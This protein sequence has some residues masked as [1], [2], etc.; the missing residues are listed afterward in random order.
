MKRLFLFGAIVLAALIAISFISNQKAINTDLNSFKARNIVRCSPDWDYVNTILEDADIPPMPGAGKY[1]WK[2]RTTND[3]AQFYFNQ[4]INMY[5]GFH[6]IEALASFQKAAKFDPQNPMLWW[7]QALAYGPNINDVGYKANVE[8]YNAAL[9]AKELMQNVQ[10][11]EQLLIEAMTTRYSEDSTISREKLNQAYVDGMQKA[12]RQYQN[13]IDVATLYADA[14][15]LQHPWDL[16]FNNGK[17]KTWTPVIRSVLEGVLRKNPEH[18]GANH[19]YIH[20]MEASPE[21]AKALPSA[22][23]LGSL[24][25]GLAHMV[26]MPSHIYLRTGNFKKGSQINEEAIAQFQKYSSLFPAVQENIFIYL[27]HNRHMQVNCALLA[28]RYEYAKKA[29]EELRQ[30]IDTSYLSL[31][32]PMGAAVQYIYMTPVLLDVHFGKWENILQLPQPKESHLY[33]MILHSFARGMA[34]AGQNKLQDAH[35][36]FSRLQQLMK[37]SSL[38]IPFGAFSSAY[39]G[40]VVAGNILQGSIALKEKKYTEA[41]SFFDKAVK[42]EENMVYNEPRDWILNPKQYAG[43]AYLAAG[44]WEKAEE[45]FRNDLHVNDQNVWALNGLRL[46]LEK[47]NKNSEAKKIVENLEIAYKE[48]RLELPHKGMQNGEVLFT[49]Y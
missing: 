22:D 47:Q 11:F 27:L 29:A 26:H 38:K 9:K 40:A 18:P 3:S 13:N 6:I 25:P 46:S 19:Y 2:L 15:M 36:E 35:H 30:G 44:Q 45:I 4:G 24:T 12:F 34:F 5:Y 32:A 7:A 42:A 17:P 48:G 37:D 21:A 41:N 49:D 31:D 28:G 33:A 43:M 8:A 23:R 20:V 10:P 14:M 1:H 16:W 39:D